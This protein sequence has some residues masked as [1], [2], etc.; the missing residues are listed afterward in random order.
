MQLWIRVL[1]DRPIGWDY[2]QELTHDIG[3]AEEEY[4]EYYQ[5]PELNFNHFHGK[6]KVKYQIGRDTNDVL[7]IHKTQVSITGVEV[8]G[9]EELHGIPE[10]YSVYFGMKYVRHFDQYG[11]EFTDDDTYI[12]GFTGNPYYYLYPD[13]L[14]PYQTIYTEEIEFPWSYNIPINE[15]SKGGKNCYPYELYIRVPGSPE[16][17]YTSVQ[18]D[19]VCTD[20]YQYGTN[21]W[22]DWISIEAFGFSIKIKVV[23][24]RL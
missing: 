14:T 24:N 15:R 18:L 3:I 21:Y 12:S 22:S 8:T 1:Q 4:G 2:Y 10:R 13:Q 11:E 16:D 6:L 5:T 17:Y 23:V 19:D 9:L 7:T 20:P